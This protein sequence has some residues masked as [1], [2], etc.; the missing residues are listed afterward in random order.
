M[1]IDEDTTNV[2]IIG[3]K[4]IPEFGALTILVLGLSILGIVYVARKSPFVHSLTR[5]N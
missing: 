1:I 4:V 2:E 5:I 3:S